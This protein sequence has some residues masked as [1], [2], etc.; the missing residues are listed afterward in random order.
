MRGLTALFLAVPLGASLAFPQPTQTGGDTSSFNEQKVDANHQKNIDHDKKQGEEIAKEVAK[1]VKFSENKE[2]IARVTRI[3]DEIAAI[4]NKEAVEVTWG[5]ARLSPFDYKFH[6]V[7]GEDVNAFSVPGGYIYVYEGLVEFAETDDEL[8]GVLAHEVAHASF[9][10]IAT[11]QKKQSSLDLLTLGAILAAI[12][13]PRDAGNI[14]FPTGLAIRGVQS[15]WSVSAEEA[16]DF[17]AL[18]Y[19]MKSK[20]NPLGTLTFMERL[21]YRDRFLP[22]ID[23]GIYQ[24]H[25]HAD[26][27]AKTHVK[28]LKDLDIAIQRSTVTTSLKAMNKIGDA[29]IELWFGQTKIHVFAGDEAQTRAD[30]AT[31]HLNSF[32]DRVPALYD[33]Q[34]RNKAVLFGGNE[35]LFDV[36]PNDAEATKLGLDASVDAAYQALRKAVF[37]LGYRTWATRGN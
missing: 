14:L 31:D 3:G 11:M 34:V 16:A 32:F 4:A 25:P 37:D 6:V 5:D 26:E 13:S 27:R 20:Y 12:W 1:Q 9:R 28:R 10:H 35:R 2:Y 22:K 19:V 18:Q 36:S 33:V 23:W 17:G 30:R 7:K 21:A 15:G 29:G 8:A 24:T